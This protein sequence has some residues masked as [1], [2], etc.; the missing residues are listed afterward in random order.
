LS[1]TQ[2]FEQIAKFDKQRHDGAD[3]VAFTDRTLRRSAI[4]LE[5]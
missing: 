2:K 5:R 4:L 3:Q 1:L